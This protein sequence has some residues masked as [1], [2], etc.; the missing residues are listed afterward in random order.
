M[1][2]ARRHVDTATPGVHGRITAQLWSLEQL[3]RRVKAWD[4]LDREQRLARLRSPGLELEPDRTIT[5]T[6]LVVDGLLEELAHL[7]D[8][9]NKSTGTPAT[10]LALGEG[11]TAASGS[12]TSLEAEVHRIK[13]GD[14]D[15]DT[16]GPDLLTSSF[17]SQ[18]EA[19]GTTITELGLCAG[20]DQS[21]TLLTR[22]VLPSGDEVN[23]TSN[24]VVTFDYVI[25][26]RRPA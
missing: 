23:K 16:A 11:T 1:T 13:V 6:N 5:T 8:P 18:A 10:H 17:L 21:A 12:D 25:Q 20:P 4:V 7:L 24:M 26:F 2:T 22:A 19:N 14:S 9:V 15:V 3:R